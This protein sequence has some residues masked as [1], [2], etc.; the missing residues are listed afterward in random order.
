MNHAAING[1]Q[2]RT[3]HATGA[4][5]GPAATL[6]AGLGRPLSRARLN[7]VIHSGGQHALQPARA[8]P[9]NHSASLGARL[10]TGLLLAFTPASQRPALLTGM[11]CK[12]KY[13]GQEKPGS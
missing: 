13:K 10:G 4:V 5:T 6:P 9:A 8:L 3:G 1:I 2:P 7:T 12:T 11:P